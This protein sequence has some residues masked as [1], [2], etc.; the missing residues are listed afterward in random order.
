MKKFIIGVVIGAI[1]GAVAVYAYYKL[2]PN[3]VIKEV[4]TYKTHYVVKPVTLE[5]Y[6]KC[7]ESKIKIQAEARDD[8]IHV[9]AADDCKSAE[10]DIAIECKPDNKRTI[11]AAIAGVVAGAVTMLAILL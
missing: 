3:V 1:I 7:Y 6:R 4:T 5:D 9:R 2:K 8:I 11:I 10:A